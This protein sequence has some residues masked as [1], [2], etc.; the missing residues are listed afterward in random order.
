MYSIPASIS[1]SRADMVQWRLV[2][3][4]LVLYLL[5]FIDRANIGNAKIEGMTESLNLSGVDYNIA[6][7]VFFVPYTLLGES[8]H[9]ANPKQR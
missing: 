2:P 4:L 7:A 1:T 9:A 5:S 8:S 3:M 6:L